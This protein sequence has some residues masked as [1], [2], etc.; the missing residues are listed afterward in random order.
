MKVR[1]CY[2]CPIC[3]HIVAK[4]DRRRCKGSYM[5]MLGGARLKLELGQTPK[6]KCTCGH[7]LRLRDVVDNIN[8]WL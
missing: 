1:G 3:R 8:H 2:F 6:I 7:L 5:V 4:E